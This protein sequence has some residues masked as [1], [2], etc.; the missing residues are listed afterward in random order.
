MAAFW[1]SVENTVSMACSL[2]TLFQFYEGQGVLLR[3]MVKTLLVDGHAAA[4]AA[5]KQ[6]IGIKTA[7]AA[8]VCF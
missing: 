7:I 1:L 8:L 6:A 5:A 4:F 2:V 3:E